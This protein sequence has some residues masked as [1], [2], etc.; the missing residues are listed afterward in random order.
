MAKEGDT[1]G[2]Q[3]VSALSSAEA[4]GKMWRK[5]ESCCCLEWD[6]PGVP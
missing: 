1:S 2:R 3:E 5:S 6:F 4:S